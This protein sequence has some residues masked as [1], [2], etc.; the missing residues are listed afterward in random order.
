M[1]STP[2]LRIQASAP[3]DTVRQLVAREAVRPRLTRQT[4]GIRRMGWSM[5][6]AYSVNSIATKLN[7]LLAFTGGL[8]I[9]RCSLG[10]AAREAKRLVNP[11]RM[12][13][14]RG[15]ASSTPLQSEPV[16]LQKRKREQAFQSP[17]SY[18]PRTEA[19]ALLDLPL[20]SQ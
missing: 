7:R 17:P 10:F 11:L 16:L 4:M 6:K 5:S 3:A 20:R 15:P 18:R 12:R 13:N 8:R 14:V 1:P 2:G 9:P 19:A